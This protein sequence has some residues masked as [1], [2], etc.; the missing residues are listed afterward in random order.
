VAKKALLPR[1]SVGDSGMKSVGTLP[2]ITEGATEEG[3]NCGEFFGPDRVGCHGNN[4]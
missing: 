3:A 4:D 2:P 1:T